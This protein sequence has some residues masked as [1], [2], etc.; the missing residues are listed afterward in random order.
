MHGRAPLAILAAAALQT[1]VIL[2][3]TSG[4]QTPGPRPSGEQRITYA[5]DFEP[6]GIDPHVNQSINAHRVIANVF[7]PLVYRDASGRFHPGLAESWEVAPDAKTFVFHL[8]TGV[9]FHDG[10]AFDARSVVYSFDRIR[11]PATRSQLAV[12]LLGPIAWYEAADDRTL[13]VRFTMAYPA[14]LDALSYA[15]LAPVSPAAVERY[16]ADFGR[17]LVGTGPFR[18]AEWVAQDHI[19]LERNPDYAWAPDHFGRQGPPTLESVTFTFVPDWSTRSAI[20]ET[21]EADISSDALASDIARLRDNEDLQVVVTPMAGVPQSY[22]LNT[23]RQP[24]NDRRVRLALLKSVDRETIIRTLHAG[25]FEPAVGPL[26][27][28]TTAFASAP[29]R[30]D[31]SFDPE[32]ARRLLD[33]AG[34]KP[35]P[36]GVRQKDGQSLR[37]EWLSMTINRDPEQAELL[38]GLLRDFGIDL[39][40]TTV[41]TYPSL[42]AAIRADAYHII[43]TFWLSSDPGVLAQIF[44]SSAIGSNNWSKA[45]IPALDRLL[46]RAGAEPDA[47]KRAALYAEAQR[48][49]MDEVLII[50]VWDTANVLVARSSVSGLRFDHR[51]VYVWLYGVSVTR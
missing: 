8:R 36:D 10:T 29:V 51:G 44:H 1:A 41:P 14:F 32:G 23:A 46:E 43:P 50:P 49:I 22:A 12:S 38:Q 30:G 31:S 37:L 48:S 19:R 17:H 45:Q 20:L 40:I 3:C 6:S 4:M 35:G 28:T 18:L 27:R 39:S 11:D 24:L 25:A 13:R 47:A 34:W 33:E 42:I 16:G 5:L 26:T 2:A 7:D 9:R 15:W 21:G